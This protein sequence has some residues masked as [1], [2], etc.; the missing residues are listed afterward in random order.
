[1]IHISKKAFT[2][3]ELLVVITILAIISVVAFT[4]FWWVTDKAIKT[5]KISDIASISNALVQ[6]KIK[7]NYYPKVDVYNATT[8]RWWYDSAAVAKRS[9]IIEVTSSDN[10]I[11]TIDTAN[12][13]WKIFGTW[14][15]ILVQI[16]GKWT[17]S[18]KSLWKQYLSEDLYDPEIWDIKTNNWTFIEEWIWR[19]TYAIYKKNFD[20]TKW[21]SY[22]LAYT[23][24]NDDE[25]YITKISWDFDEN[26]CRVKA[27]CPTSLIWSWTVVLNGNQKLTSSDTRNEDQW[28]PYPVADF[29]TP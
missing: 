19:Y 27:N 17:I 5:R 11:E 3:V 23:M 18:Q 20:N 12:W 9:N 7:N 4:S 22:N 26:V 6:Y 25:E 14:S 8:N 29:Y 10:V 28:I 21:T 1:M 2:L 13:G 15:D 16:W 24:I